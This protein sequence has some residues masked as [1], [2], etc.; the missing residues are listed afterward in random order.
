MNSEHLWVNGIHRIII[1]NELRL[2]IEILDRRNALGTGTWFNL[3]R[4]KVL[5]LTTNGKG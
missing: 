3:G 5:I 2:M 1:Y 4:R